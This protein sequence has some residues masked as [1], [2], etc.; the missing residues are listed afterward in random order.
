MLENRFVDLPNGMRLSYA[1][2]GHRFGIP[3]LLL[4]GVTDSW[5]SFS[6]LMRHL[7]SSLRVVAVSQRGHGDSTHPKTDYA[8]DDFAADLAAV[9]DATG[10]DKAIIVGHSMSSSIAQCFALRYPARVLGL[11]LV[12]SFFAGWRASPAVRE[13]W[14][15]TVSKLTDPVDRDFVHQFQ[16]ST[17]ARQLPTD[18][19]N[20]VIGES[21]KVPARVWRAVFE[22]FLEADFSAQIG[23]VKVPALVLWGDK[24]A[25]CPLSEQVAL[26]A[27]LE[28][29][30]L[31]I[32]GSCGHAPHWEAPERF[33]V[34]LAAFA[35][36]VG[37]PTTRPRFA[38]KAA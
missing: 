6:P 20:G 19:L 4:H 29:A 21:L 9:M 28:S 30:E 23:G 36:R 34:D 25:I 17:V 27:A 16:E 15:T 33:A 26:T 2:Q 14:D 22:G 38:R 3:V 12:G 37:A 10:F 24:D 8:P 13:L 18:F 7:P 1:E 35:R 11:V 32:Y 5:R 31:S